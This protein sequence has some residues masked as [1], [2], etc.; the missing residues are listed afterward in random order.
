MVSSLLFPYLEEKK[1]HRSAAQASS[2]ERGA[3]VVFEVVAAVS[4]SLESLPS[5][6]LVAQ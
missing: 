2:S 4:A 6:V 1:N 3:I 5:F